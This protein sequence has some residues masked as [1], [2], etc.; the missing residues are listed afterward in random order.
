MARTRVRAAVATGFLDPSG[1]IVTATPAR[2]H[3][4]RSMLSYPTPSRAMIRG[5][6][7]GVAKEPRTT[8]GAPKAMPSNPATRSGVKLGSSLAKNS[9]GS[10]ESVSMLMSPQLNP[11]LRSDIS[12]DKPMR[13]CF[14]ILQ[15]D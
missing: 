9:H 15:S 1:V 5:D 4:A 13:N 14:K 3:S 11:P 6:S 8:P 10:G 12:A 7:S 2:V